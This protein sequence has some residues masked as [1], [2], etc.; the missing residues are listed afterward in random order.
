MKE[1][2][3][4]KKLHI[5]MWNFVIEVLDSAQA[6]E[7]GLVK[8]KLLKKQF[9][10]S[11]LDEVSN[12][13]NRNEEIQSLLEKGLSRNDFACEFAGGNCDNCPLLEANGGRLDSNCFEEFSPHECLCD[14]VNTY[15]WKLAVALAEEIRDAWR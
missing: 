9:L 3:T 5:Q 15:E 4:F 7:V 6:P 2:K 8:I 13:A 12:K 11:L 14:C 10:D 1:E